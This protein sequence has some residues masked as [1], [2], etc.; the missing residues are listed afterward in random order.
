MKITV[1]DVPPRAAWALE[2]TGVHPLL[3][4]LYAARGVS[5]KEQLD[6]GLAL[7]LPPSSLKGVA[8]AAVLLALGVRVAV[9]VMPPSPLIRFDNTP[10]GT[11]TSAIL[12][13]CTASVTVKVTV[14]VSPIFSAV[15][16]MV[17][18]LARLGR[19]VSMA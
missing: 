2:Q 3:A 15:S 16:E 5:T 4:R 1:R 19:T 17:M 13:P 6:D 11:A 12:K 8:D 9:Q 10:F 7:L 14:A 18:L